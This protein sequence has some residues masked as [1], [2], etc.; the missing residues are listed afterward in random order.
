MKTKSIGINLFL[1]LFVCVLV[2]NINTAK[3]ETTDTSGNIYKQLT[4]VKCDS[5]IK[6]NAANPNF[7]ILD[8]RTPAEY[9]SYHLMGAINR[10]TGDANFDAQLAALPKHKLFLLHCQS[11]GRS[12]GAFAKMKNLGY[13]EVYEMIGGL[14]SWNAAKLPTTT[15]TGPKLMLVSKSN[16]ISGSN[17]DTIKITITNR[18]NEKLTFIS[19]SVSDLHSVNHN[20]NNGVAIEGSFDYTFSV[21]HSPKYSGTDSTKVKLESNGGN[22]EISILYKNGIVTEIEEQQITELNVYPNPATSKF[23]IEG[24]GVQ[25]LK[26]IS[27]ISLTGKR[28]LS[29]NN[30]FGMDGIDISQLQNG[31][32]IVQIKAANQTVSKKLVIQK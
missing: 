13:A 4:A 10:S 18:A 25:E 14:N 7:V 5:L 20:F 28:V 8:V 16:I 1:M 17:S 9:S 31:I 3:A 19:V 2:S 23:F 32:Y 15:V 30:V 11:G 24:S 27:I 22:L 29:K 6:A 12:A 26:E 21:F